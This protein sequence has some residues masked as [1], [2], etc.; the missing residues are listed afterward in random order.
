MMQKVAFVYL[1]HYCGKNNFN[2]FIL[3]VGVNPGPH[4]GGATKGGICES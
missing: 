4:E 3:N 2:L 1:Q